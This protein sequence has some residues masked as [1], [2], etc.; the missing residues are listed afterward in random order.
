VCHLNL[1]PLLDHA[2]IAVKGDW[3]HEAY[4]LFPVHLDGT[5]FDN[6]N[7]M[8]SRKEFYSTADVLQIFHQGSPLLRL[9]H[10]IQIS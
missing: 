6:A 3:S 8:L 1:L 2:I 9:D 4:L 5:L 7:I 10:Y